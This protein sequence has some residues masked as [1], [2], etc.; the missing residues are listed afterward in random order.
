MLNAE[1]RSLDAM[2]DRIARSTRRM[3]SGDVIW[4]LCRVIHHLCRCVRQARCEPATMVGR[5]LA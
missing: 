2:A 1:L 5:A 3:K 4:H